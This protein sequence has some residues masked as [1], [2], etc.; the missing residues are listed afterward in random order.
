MSNG[1]SLTVLRTRTFLWFGIVVFG[2]LY[3][4]LLCDLAGRVLGVDALCYTWFLNIPSYLWVELIVYGPLMWFALH[5]VNTDVFGDVPTDPATLKTHRRRQLVGTAAIAVFFYGVGVHVADTVEVFAREHEDITSGAV[6]DLIYFIDEGLSHYIQF[7][8]LFFVVGWFLIF[9]RQGRTGRRRLALFFGA[10]HGVERGLG[11]V[12]GEKW[13]LGPAV[14]AWLFAA[15]WLRWRRVGTAAI[16]EFFFR[17]AIAFLV[18]LPTSQA[19]Y[20]LRFGAF[21][22][23]SA[24]PDGE[25]A[26]VVVGA[27]ALTVLGTAAIIALDRGMRSHYR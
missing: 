18:L 15:A 16:D 14:F 5:Q 23:P 8:S 1:E 21:T 22:P 24:L 20:G 3:T 25:Y 6:Y 19:V 13:F 17:Y 26:Q 7:V 9:D 2:R 11:V 27:V 4:V 12:E 10:A